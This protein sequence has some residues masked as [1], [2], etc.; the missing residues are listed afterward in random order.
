MSK[1]FKEV[2]G[3]VGAI[4]SVVSGGRKNKNLSTKKSYT[5]GDGALQTNIS[6]TAPIP[7]IYGT[8]KVAGNLVYS[9][10]SEDKKVIYKVISL[11]DGLVKEIRDLQ[12]D[13][14]PIDSPEFK[15]VSWNIYLGDGKQEIDNRVPGGTQE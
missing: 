15:N 12:L 3:W 6:T 14:L 7:I 8:V 9:R 13:D 1:V 2:L 4:V 10:L 11:C 5:Y